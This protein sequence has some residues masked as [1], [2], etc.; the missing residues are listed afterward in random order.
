MALI[1]TGR[2]EAADLGAHE[3]A[4]S[5]WPVH[6]TQLS[7]GGFRSISDF[8][9]TE[10]LIVYRQS[11]NQRMAVVGESPRDYVMLGTV[12]DSSAQVHWSGRDLGDQRVAYSR[13]SGEIDF[14]TSERA[15]HIVILIRADVLACS[16]GDDE[17]ANMLGAHTVS[18]KGLTPA[19]T[20][21]ALSI[22]TRYA[23][24]SDRPTDPG[25]SEEVESEVVSILGAYA[26]LTHAPALDLSRRQEALRCAIAYCERSHKPISVPELAE[27]VGISRRTL[28]Y[29]FCQGLGI[30]P[31]QYIKRERLNTAYR[32]LRTAPPEST[33]VKEIASLCGFS[34]PGRFAADYNRL[35]QEFPAQTLGKPPSLLRFL[36]R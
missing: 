4:H 10:R 33:T 5:V 2:I 14:T 17:L 7:S 12:T 29:V 25:E 23:S 24:G 32:A 28:E 19:L 16:I 26:N 35:F 27:A 36:H 1:E 13:P 21:T 3:E 20:S 9:R 18:P 30:T 22:L 15:D 31:L 11:W 34:D 6:H 8:V